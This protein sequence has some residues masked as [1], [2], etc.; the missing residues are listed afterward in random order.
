MLGVGTYLKS[1]NTLWQLI[2]APTGQS[3]KEK[4]CG[5][6]YQINYE[7]EKEGKGVQ[8]IASENKKDAKS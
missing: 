7:G 5:V 1:K 4:N 6:V 2:I 8:A 3:K